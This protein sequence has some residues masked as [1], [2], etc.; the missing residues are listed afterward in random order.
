VISREKHSRLIAG[1]PLWV[2]RQLIT[3]C[4]KL[5]LGCICR[6]SLEYR[7]EQQMRISYLRGWIHAALHR[8]EYDP[9]S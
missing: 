9:A 3:A 7:T 1:I 4:A 6:K 2:L 5:F 8:R